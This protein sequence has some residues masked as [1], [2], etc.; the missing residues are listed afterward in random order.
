MTKSVKKV[1]T[2]SNVSNERLDLINDAVNKVQG[3]NAAIT[4][5]VTEWLVHQGQLDSLEN[6]AKEDAAIGLGETVLNLVDSGQTSMDWTAP[7]AKQFAL[8]KDDA[9]FKGRK[10]FYDD[11]K[12]DIA[13]G[14]VTAKDYGL[15]TKFLERDGFNTVYGWTKKKIEKEGLQPAVYVALETAKSDANQTIRKIR[16]RMRTI[17]KGD[18][19]TPKVESTDTEKDIKDF[20]R[21]INRLLN[22]EDLSAEEVEYKLTALQEAT[23]RSGYNIDDDLKFDVE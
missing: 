14:Y 22:R 11:A 7:D 1:D 2:D 21:I 5:P 8:G 20:Q 6:A 19:K 4:P 10:T 15:P 9:A 3:S 17:E 23:G 13:F 16:E 12:R 18:D